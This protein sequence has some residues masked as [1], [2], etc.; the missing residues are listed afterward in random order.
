[1]SECERVKGGGLGEEEDDDDDEPQAGA[2]KDEIKL[3][4]Y[5]LPQN[6]SPL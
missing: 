1:M 3:I 5:L 4:C 2:H 6:S